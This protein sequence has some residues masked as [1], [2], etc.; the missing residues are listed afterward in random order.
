MRRVALPAPLTA[1]V[2]LAKQDDDAELKARF[3]PVATALADAE[4]TIV[5][6]LNAVQGA[7]VNI[8]GY[9]A[10]DPAKAEAAMRPSPTLNAAIAA[11]GRD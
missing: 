10:P 5:D 7:P 1:I 11:L 9:Y 4:Q 2:S 3:T 6:E 8:G